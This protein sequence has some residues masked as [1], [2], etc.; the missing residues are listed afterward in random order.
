[1][2]MKN[3]TEKLP[4]LLS[5]AGNLE[6]AVAAF[7]GGADA[8]YCGLGKFNARERAQNFSGAD[9]GRL[10]SFA[11]SRGKKVYLTVNTLVKETELAEAVEYLAEAA[12]LMP[13][14]LIV[15]D[16]GILRICREYFPALKLHAS[17]QMGIH[18]SAGVAAAAARGV[19]RVILERQLTLEELRAIALASPVE[20]EVF[21][22]GSLCCSLSGQCL[23]SSSAGGWSGNRGKCK[24]PCRRRFDSG[25]GRGFGLSP[26]DLYG[27]PLVP[28][29]IRLGI[30]SLK[31]EGRLRSP[32]YVW[33][34]ARAY[35]LM[36]DS[37]GAAQKEAEAL[38]RSTASRRPSK[39]FYDKK[40]WKTLIDKERL[41][42][43]GTPVAD[44]LKAE[45]GGLVLRTRE[46]LHLGDRLRLVPPNGG[47]GDSFSLTA[48][49]EKGKEVLR[50]RG[51]V[52]CFLPGELNAS[53]GFLLF[54]IGENGFDFSRQANAL[55]AAR[56]PVR[57]M[58]ECSA[59][60]WRVSVA[61]LPGE[62]WEVQTDFAPA[63]KRSLTAEE[64]ARE[65]SSGVPEPYCAPAPE[66]VFDGAFFVPA[67]RL[68]SLRRE[69]WNWAAAR[70]RSELL[71]SADSAGLWRFFQAYNAPVEKT[72]IA[73]ENRIF[74]IPGFI[75]EARLAPMRQAIQAAYA[76][77]IR[78]FR[79][80][81][82]HGFALLEAF[83]G[84]EIETVFPLHVANSM[85]AAELKAYGAVSVQAAVELESASLAALR[86]KSPLPVAGAVNVPPVL[87]TRLELP[88]GEWR[89]SAGKRLFCRR[90]DGV[91]QLYSAEAKSDE[92]GGVLPFCGQEWL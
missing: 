6:C 75:P 20:L 77:G 78:R 85:A 25:G 70:L 69:F 38:L 31:I 16:L 53:A 17:T 80:G 1:M 87:T 21:I 26:R 57:L 71:N 14:A 50:V 11:R 12:R 73:G 15:Q 54:K 30:A 13:D 24:Q 23:L 56:L 33:K 8:V 9:L 27:L 29:M 74:V 49:R 39:G 37:A 3:E 84:V 60:R 35:R 46:R 72:E 7:D 92:N 89:D 42:V 58:L 65:F 76:S 10:I 61:E 90:Q 68:K 34:S 22:H 43:F 32:D 83:P 44:V 55:P 62:I 41:G 82:I 86:E 47:D 66:A 81:G 48:L 59:A 36:L 52:E 64:V 91:T 19:E 79:V 67:S 5:P 63:E 51:G 88:P 18:N 28:E 2:D 45:R 4:E 40:E